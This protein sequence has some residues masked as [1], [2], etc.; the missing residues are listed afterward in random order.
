[1]THKILI[2]TLFGIFVPF[3]LN[4]SDIVKGKQIWNESCVSCHTSKPNSGPVVASYFAA[5]QWKRFIESNKHK[6]IEE[7]KLNKEE[8]GYVLEYL[9][10]HA[11][12]SDSPEIAGIR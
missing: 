3:L 2:I 9:K 5:S 7:I 8:L 1:M 6:S 11:A 12:D 10:K 4:A